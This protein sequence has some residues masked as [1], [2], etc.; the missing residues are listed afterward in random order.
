MR[1]L[2]LFLGLT[3]GACAMRSSTDRAAVDMGG[4]HDAAASDAASTDATSTDAA[5]PDDMM[6]VA[7]AP[8]TDAGSAH[9]A[10]HDLG[11]EACG[12]AVCTTGSYCCAAACNLCLPNTMFCL[13]DPCAGVDAGPRD[14]GPPHDAGTTTGDCR[15]T[16]C[17]GRSVCM[18][19]FTSWA[20]LPAGAVC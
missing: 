20:C 9:D 1:F 19:C 11:G 4:T 12:S 13:A 5:S 14:A 17:S 3:V 16:G 18:L 10:A 6:S 8:S 7:D 15:T 2:L